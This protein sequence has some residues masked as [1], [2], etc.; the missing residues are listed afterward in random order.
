MTH[1]GIAKLEGGPRDG[2][3]IPLTTVSHD[4]VFADAVLHPD[5]EIAQGRYVFAGGTGT[6]DTST[7]TYRWQENS[8][9]SAG[10]FHVPHGSGS[11]DSI[12]CPAATGAPQDYVTETDR[13]RAA[14]AEAI[15]LAHRYRD[16]LDQARDVVRRVLDL[17]SSYD[18]DR[19]I[20][21]KLVNNLQARG[22][23][24]G[25]LP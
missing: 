15:E 4:L 25:L 23:L 9:G 22:M 14:H 8:G 2:E 18:A 6:P 16:E 19:G 13:L 24:E 20:E 3:T 12:V 1:V 17:T 10:G 5:S 11:N 21:T 7:I